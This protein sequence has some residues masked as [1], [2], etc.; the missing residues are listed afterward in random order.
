[1]SQIIENDVRLIR[2]MLICRLAEDQANYVAIRNYLRDPGGK[3]LHFLLPE[4]QTSEQRAGFFV[5]LNLKERWLADTFGCV[6]LPDYFD[7]IF[8]NSKWAN[9]FTLYVRLT[10]EVP[11]LRETGLIHWVPARFQDIWRELAKANHLQ[12]LQLIPPQPKGWQRIRQFLT[13]R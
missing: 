4:E 2:R 13:G 3:N 8:L 9:P 11:V 12:Y 10:E 5:R 7:V 6:I 1:M